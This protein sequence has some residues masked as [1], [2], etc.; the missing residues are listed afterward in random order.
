MA[1]GQVGPPQSLLHPGRSHTLCPARGATSVVYSC[2]EKGTGA[3]YAA[4]ILK[5]TVSARGDAG[6]TGP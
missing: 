1:G 5:K 6:V 3:P 4:K 2:E